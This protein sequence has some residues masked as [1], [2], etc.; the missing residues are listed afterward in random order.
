VPTRDRQRRSAQL[1]A[2]ALELS[3]RD[4]GAI[5]ILVAQ[6]ARTQGVGRDAARDAIIDS[7]KAFGEKAAA[8]PDTATAVNALVSFVTTPR[9]TL[10]IK[11]TPRAKVP[12]VQFLDLLK[13]DPGIALAQFRIEA[14]TG[15]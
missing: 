13:T 14:S 4:L 10:T 2:G 6:Y 7:I 12:A 1:E 15:L 5:D 3:L 11:L 8:N 9:Q